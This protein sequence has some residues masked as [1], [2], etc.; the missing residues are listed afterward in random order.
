VTAYW[1][2]ATDTMIQENDGRVRQLDPTT[3]AVMWEAPLTDLTPEQL[4]TC[5]QA[6]EGFPRTGVAEVDA[7]FDA[8][9]EALI[10]SKPTP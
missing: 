5:R 1:N 4:A 7:G 2:A 8:L 10:R 6:R 3:G 9:L